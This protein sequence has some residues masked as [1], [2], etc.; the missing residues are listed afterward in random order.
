MDDAFDQYFDQYYDQAFENFSNNIADQE[1]KNRELTSKEIVKK[2][3]YVYGMII[4][5][6]LQHILQ[7]YFDNDFEWTNICSC[8]LFIDSPMK[9]NSFNQKKMLSEGPVSLH[10]KSVQQPFVSWHMAMR[11]MR[12]TNTSGSVQ[13]QLGHVWNILWTE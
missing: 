1:K 7:I 2:A 11:L 3:I 6:T 9:F 10:F 13:L 8:I 12:S 5:A 4:S